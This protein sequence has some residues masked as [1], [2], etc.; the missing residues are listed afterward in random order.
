MSKGRILDIQNAELGESKYL[1]CARFSF[2]GIERI[3]RKRDSIQETILEQ[4][5]EK[6]KLQHDIRILADRLAKANEDLC[7]KIT[8]RDSY[9]KLISE[10]EFAYTKALLMSL[11]SKDEESTNAN[12]R[13]R[14]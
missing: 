5:E 1:I 10:S 9:D 8:L 11:R 12:G 4:E 14:C 13:N 6:N 3:R 2:K 7:L